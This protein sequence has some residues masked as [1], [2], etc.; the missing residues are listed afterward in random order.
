MHQNTA[1][2]SYLAHPPAIFDF[3]GE[4]TLSILTLQPRSRTACA[5]SNVG[6]F[7]LVLG[8]ISYKLTG[9]EALLDTG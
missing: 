1:S 8:L 9:R 3:G 7:I 6:S 4:T 2:Q 5:A